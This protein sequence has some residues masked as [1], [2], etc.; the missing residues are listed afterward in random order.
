MN[1]LPEAKGQ[2]PKDSPGSFLENSILGGQGGLGVMFTV[3]I[4]KRLTEMVR[5]M[6]LLHF[7]LMTFRIHY[8]K[9]RKPLIFMVLGPGGHDHDS[10]NQLFLILKAP[11]Y[12]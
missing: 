2:L 5:R 9:T 11:R 10:Q 12:C 7:G 6:I 8:W 3:N 1:V 4:I